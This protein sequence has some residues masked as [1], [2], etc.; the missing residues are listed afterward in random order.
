MNGWDVKDRARMLP[1][2]LPAD[3]LETIAPIPSDAP[4]AYNQLVAAL[5][6]R[7]GSN[8]GAE[9]YQALLSARRQGPKETVAEYAKEIGILTKK[10]YPQLNEDHREVIARRVFLTGLRDRNLA[11]NVQCFDPKSLEKTAAKALTLEAVEADRAFD[12][13]YPAGGG[14]VYRPKVS[15]PGSSSRRSRSSPWSPTPPHVRT[16]RLQWISPD[17]TIKRTTVPVGGRRYS[18]VAEGPQ[19]R[20][21]AP[22]ASPQ[23]GRRVRQT[24]NGG[25]RSVTVLVSGNGWRAGAMPRTSAGPP[26]SVRRHQP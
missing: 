3:C 11:R 10:A 26:T 7:Y 4:D 20:V 8:S 24:P 14:P 5:M 6:C 15:R 13:D 16:A 21:A 2:F 9:I 22:P 23:E 18:D 19:R 25:R 17:R 1:Q 12:V